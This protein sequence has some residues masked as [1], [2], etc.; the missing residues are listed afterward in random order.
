MWS[1]W[2]QIEV[3]TDFRFGA[4]SKAQAAS[5]P[6]GALGTVGE[7]QL[8][9]I[10][11]FEH[12]GNDP[13]HGRGVGRDGHEMNDD[14]LFPKFEHSWGLAEF[15]K[16]IVIV[17]KIVVGDLEGLDGPLEEIARDDA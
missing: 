3:E 12:P 16:V 10:E 2:S 4:E 5:W 6:V 17:P 7:T 9:L 14:L 13:A 1:R 8:G 11:G 15:S